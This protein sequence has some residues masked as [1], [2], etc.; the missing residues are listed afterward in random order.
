MY[1][2]QLYTSCLAEAAYYIES[3]G[4]SAIIDPLRETA[5]YLEMAAARGSNIKYIFET[6]FHADFV[7]GH[8]DLAQQ[9]SATIVYGPHANPKFDAWIATDGQRF[10]IGKLTL[11]VLHTPGH[12][13]ESSC[14]LLYDE[15]GRPH[16]LFSGDTLFVGAVG[17][18]DLAVKGEQPTTAEE[19]ASMM[20]DSLRNKIMPLA[21]EVIVYP[22]HGPG[23]ACGK[24]IGKET[25]STLGI[26]KATNYALQPMSREEFIAKATEDLPPPP[27]YFF[28][29][30]R[31]N[32]IGYDSF[33]QVMSRNS[34]PLSADEVAAAVAEGAIVLD[35]RS[36]DAFEKG[37]IPGA[38]NI[39]LNGGFAVWVGTLLSMHPP[40]ILVADE[41]RVSESI[42]R[43]ARV[44]YE[45]VSGYLEGGVA[46]WTASG[47]TLDQV[48]SINAEEVSALMGDA[49]FIDVR[50]PSEYAAGHIS[51]ARHMELD[52][53][54]SK[55]ATL[56]Q[57]QKYVVNCQG[58]YRSMVAASI[59]KA[60]GIH[61]VINVT[62][63][64]AAICKT[65]TPV[66]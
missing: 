36:A 32:Q 22:A 2:E 50:K 62:G 25:W 59:L 20:Y 12:T 52:G 60:H 57:N 19:L 28:E 46:A 45:N 6:H 23:S 53:L 41:D 51:G 13:M 47:R 34:S 35:T 3:E 58:G 31:I 37:F 49:V 5:P 40:I 16:A 9:T 11:E 43:L 38:L 24:G 61:Q 4:E 42:M 44:G 1:I 15:S 48:K 21:D 30:A 54:A 56:H 17:R 63:G 64:F 65:S 10:Q 33:S 26:Q 8:L 39:G 55:I 27:A 7:S 29:D 18:P 66:E 14:F